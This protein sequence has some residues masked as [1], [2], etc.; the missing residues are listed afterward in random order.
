MFFNFIK[1]TFE[2]IS[3]FLLSRYFS[4]FIAF[5]F[6]EWVKNSKTDKNLRYSDDFFGAHTCKQFGCVVGRA[7]DTATVP[8]AVTKRLLA[9]RW[10]VFGSLHQAGHQIRRGPAGSGLF[11]LQQ[12]RALRAG[13]RF[14]GPRVRVAGATE[15]AKHN[16]LNQC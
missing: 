9:Y 13:A 6:D 2:N 14:F 7:F 11:P 3:N 16:T 8:P 4:L 5:Y 15:A 10:R 1:K 12:A